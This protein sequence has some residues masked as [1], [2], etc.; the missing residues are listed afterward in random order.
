MGTVWCEKNY[1]HS[2]IPRMRWSSIAEVQAK[3]NETFNDDAMVTCFHRSGV[4][5][6]P[7]SSLCNDVMG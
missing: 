1:H 2:N 7:G 6:A 3:S 4:I 5:A